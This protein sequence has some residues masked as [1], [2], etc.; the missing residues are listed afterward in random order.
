MKLSE[1]D[2]MQAT[3]NLQ[4][5][6]ETWHVELYLARLDLAGNGRLLNILKVTRHGCGPDAFPD[7]KTRTSD[8]FFL[9]D[10]LMDIDSERQDNMSDSLV[11]ATI[12]IYKGKPYFELYTADHDWGSLLT[13]NGILS[14]FQYAHAA[15]IL[16]EFPLAEVRGDGPLTVCKIQYLHDSL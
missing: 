2:I 12:E 5:E 8:L 10:S 4:P 16:R 14:V 11:H 13:G 15:Q 6:A 9:K 3:E 1:K 7:D